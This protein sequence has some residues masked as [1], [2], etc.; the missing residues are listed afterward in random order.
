MDWADI[1]AMILA[2]CE[3]KFLL[4]PDYILRDVENFDEDI[5]IRIEE[6]EEIKKVNQLQS[7]E[8]LKMLNC[9][10]SLRYIG[11][12]SLVIKI[13]INGKTIYALCDTGSDLNLINKP[14]VSGFNIFPTNTQDRT[15]NNLELN[16]IGYA[17]IP[18]LIDGKKE[19]SKFYVCDDINRS[20]IVELPFLR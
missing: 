13:N 16:I 19:I 18:I 15:A 7:V 6:V 3:K 2:N 12:E 17:N 5:I 11:K 4:D 14:L 8:K 9:N 1:K 10:L 20:C